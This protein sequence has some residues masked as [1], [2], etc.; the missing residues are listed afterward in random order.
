[1]S[2][3]LTKANTSLFLFISMMITAVI[4]AAVDLP[5]AQR[6]SGILLLYF[7]P[8]AVLLPLILSSGEIDGITRVFLSFAISLVSV[9]LGYLFLCF[10]LGRVTRPMVL[11]LIVSYGLLSF[12]PRLW[13]GP[14]PAGLA[15]K[16][17][18]RWDTLALII[19]IIAAFFRFAH[20]GYAEYQGDEAGNCLLN[21]LNLVG[22]KTWVL[23]KPESTAHPR[24]PTQVLIPALSFLLTRTFD[25]GVT[26]MPFALAGLASV[27]LLYV[28]GRDMFSSPLAGFVAGLSAA[29]NGYLV[30]FSRIVQYQ[31]IVVLST[32]LAMLFLWRFMKSDETMSAGKYLFL[33]TV[34]WAFSVLSH[35][36]GLLFFPVVAYA[37]L[38]R[39]KRMGW[40]ESM[41]WLI[42]LCVLFLL[43]T[44]LFYLPLFMD[45]ATG[46][47]LEKHWKGRHDASFHFNID[48]F[49]T[50]IP[51]YVSWPYM[52]AMI[53]LALCSFLNGYKKALLMIILWFSSFFVYY[54]VI[55]KTP[56]T[57]VLTFFP[58]WALLT[59][60]GLTSINN[61]I[62]KNISTNILVLKLNIFIINLIALGVGILTILHLYTLFIN[63]NPE[64]IWCRNR[65]EI[66]V[67]AIFGFPYH[68]G[69]KTIGALFRTGEF[70]GSYNTNEQT[71]IAKFY[72]RQSKITKI[73]AKYL[74][75]VLCPQNFHNDYVVGPQ[76][77]LVAR[78]LSGGKTQLL[79]FQEMTVVEPVKDYD[80][81]ELDELYRSLDR[82]IM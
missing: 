18:P 8:G 37:L 36:E 22:G 48:L 45:S 44:A 26:R 69:W 65:M 5:M 19:L 38:Y 75:K 12:L 56:Q 66:P 76:Y 59:G 30:A 81:R 34:F 53:I 47:A 4:N 43:I 74:V 52:V 79:L 14:L 17:Y 70:G 60:A 62:T 11:S 23:L 2:I 16:R 55:C 25:E 31:S 24:P 3:I 73:N 49:S 32:V 58:A 33:G 54:M 20:L 57:H 61:Y 82:K 15:V 7:L 67:K 6:I 1:M 28:L 42:G 46:H 35:Y 40:K 68:R 51:L 78:F 80:V 13:K 63:H 77:Q 29:L 50:S 71:K 41:L 9:S 39:A 10:A 21:S 27:W 72:L 64:Y